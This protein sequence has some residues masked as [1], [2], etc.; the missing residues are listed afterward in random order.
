[1]DS[2]ILEKLNSSTASCNN[3][4]SDNINP[5]TGLLEHK[6]RQCVMLQKRYEDAKSA[7]KDINRSLRTLKGR[8][9]T[10]KTNI[11]FHRYSE[12]IK[13]LSDAK[14]RL[15]DDVK[16]AAGILT[17]A[18]KQLGALE[19]HIEDS[20]RLS[21]IQNQQLRDY[22]IQSK[23]EFLKLLRR[24]E[25]I[26]ALLDI[27]LYEFYMDLM[28]YSKGLTVVK[29]EKRIC[30]GCNI[31][32]PQQLFIDILETDWMVQC[33]ECMRILYRDDQGQI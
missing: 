20:R 4:K 32:L 23:K 2:L 16:K 31:F 5:L 3:N 24:R 25:E 14:K 22:V 10:I 33:P 9:A 7:F 26:K 29:A 8:K 18:M 12:E 30:S 21:E 6:K 11:E 28:N 13:K 15:E 1:M 17:E 27:E 19:H